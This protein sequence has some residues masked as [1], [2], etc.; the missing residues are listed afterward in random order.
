MH[1]P[2]KMKLLSEVCT[3][4]DM[5]PL[6]RDLASKSMGS[7]IE[8]QKVQL[9]E[10]GKLSEPFAVFCDCC[11]LTNYVIVTTIQF[12]LGWPP[13]LQPLDPMNL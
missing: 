11:T 8:T 12:L 10:L 2:S 13:S 3:F 4:V 9:Y 1:E 7:M 5:V 6:F